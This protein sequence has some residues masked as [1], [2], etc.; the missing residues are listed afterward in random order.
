MMKR[1]PSLVFLSHH[2]HHGLSIA[3]KLK[4]AGTDQ[5]RFSLEEIRQKLSEFW[6]QTGGRQHFREEEEIVF[7]VYAQY[8]P[9]EQ[10][11]FAE[12]LLEHVRIRAMVDRILNQDSFSPE[13]MNTLGLLLE[14]HIH[15]EERIIFPLIQQALPE[16]AL[17][18]I[19]GQL[20][21]LIPKKNESV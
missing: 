20:S 21:Q 5:S 9:L 14:R 17:Q 10:P 13:E 19:G 11:E 1:H 3:Q 2:H 12:A 7:P 16:D 15:K 18:R 4:K 6:Y 8:C